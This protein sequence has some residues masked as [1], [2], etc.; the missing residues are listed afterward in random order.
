MSDAIRVEHLTKALV[1]KLLHEPTVRARASAGEA[2]GMRHLES[3]MH[4]FGL[5]ASA[6]PDASS[7]RG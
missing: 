7:P 3:L 4:L 1:N 6:V 2:D 5:D